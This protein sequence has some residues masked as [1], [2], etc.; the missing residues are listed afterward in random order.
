MDPFP[1]RPIQTF[2]K[3]KHMW[4]SLGIIKFSKSLGCLGLFQL[5]EPM[6]LRTIR[7]RLLVEVFPNTV[8]GDA[9]SIFISQQLDHSYLVCGTSLSKFIGTWLSLPLNCKMLFLE[10]IIRS[11]TNQRYRLVLHLLRNSLCF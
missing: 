6:L 2:E 3:T 9:V 4:G 1:N 7:H 11:W 8:R 5:T 10:L